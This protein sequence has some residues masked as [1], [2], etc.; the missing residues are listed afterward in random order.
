LKLWRKRT[1]V[2]Y[3]HSAWRTLNGNRAPGYFGAVDR[4]ASRLQ[5]PAQSIVITVFAMV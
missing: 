5:F 4:R 3:G 2:V 1:G